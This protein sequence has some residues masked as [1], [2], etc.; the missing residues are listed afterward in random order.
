MKRDGISGLARFA[1]AWLFLTRVPLPVRVNLPDGA[2]DAQ[3]GKSDGMIPLAATV[4]AWP[5]VG[6][7]VG[8]AS[9]GALWAAALLGLPPVA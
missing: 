5:V 2:A 6:L 9:G 8:V 4:A 3:G 1:V 7:G